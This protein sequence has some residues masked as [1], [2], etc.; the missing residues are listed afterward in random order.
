LAPPATDDAVAVISGCGIPCGPVQP[1]WVGRRDPHV[2]ARRSLE[3]LGHALLD[4]PT[5]YLGARLPFLIDDVDLSS[6]PAEPRPWEHA[7]N[8]LDLLL[9]RRDLPGRLP[10]LWDQ[11][12]QA[13]GGNQ[14]AWAFPDPAGALWKFPALRP[15]AEPGIAAEPERPSLPGPEEIKFVSR[16]L[17]NERDRAEIRMKRPFG[18]AASEEAHALLREQQAERQAETPPE[19]NGRRGRPGKDREAA[20][21][22]GGAVHRALEE[23]DLLDDPRREL[24]RQRHLLLAYLAALVEGDELK[25]ALPLAES[26]L[27]TFVAGPLFARLRRLKDHVLARELSVLLPPGDGEHAPVGAVS[28]AIDLLYRDPDDGK[29]VIADYKTD[30]VETEEELRARAAV[31]APQGEVYARAVREALEMEEPPRFELWFLRAGSAVTV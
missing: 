3:R 8:P 2:A 16:V 11:A 28:G 25:R 22:A 26:L 9:S 4:E 14:P 6:T 24:E 7:R 12:L 15:P 10:D 20:M 13:A 17:Q 31:Y 23:W 29:I 27:E 18:G 21:A 30:E 1:P 19:R 5:Q